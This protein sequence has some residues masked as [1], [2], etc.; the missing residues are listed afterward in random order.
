MPEVN[1]NHYAY[2]AAGKAQAKAAKAA[3]I[4]P[5]KRG[6]GARMDSIDLEMTPEQSKK[7]R[8]KVLE[9]NKKHANPLSEMQKKKIKNQLSKMDPKDPEA[10]LLRDM[11]NLKKNK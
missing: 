11:L 7:H 9:Y 10:Q 5:S 4:D 3:N 8:K 2:T 6:T 1:G